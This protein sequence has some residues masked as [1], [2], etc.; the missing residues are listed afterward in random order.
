MKLRVL[1]V[2][3]TSGL[4]ADAVA[5]Y[6]RRAARYWPVEFVEV[7][8]EPARK[9][10]APAVLMAVE[11]VR[12]L[13]HVPAGAE[14]IALTRTGD[15]WSSR[16]LATHLEK[17]AVQGHPGAAF[18]IGGAL[19]L[20]A[21]ILRE[22]NRR[23]RLSTFTFPHDLARLILAEQLYRA[24]TIVRNEPYHKGDD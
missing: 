5:E 24:G 9:G 18:L 1:V 14:I 3:R 6:E 21:S 10:M 2:G 23:M 17:L 15:A 12:L 7:R 20:D 8:E 22:A 4:F 16:R 19:G 13:K 11:G